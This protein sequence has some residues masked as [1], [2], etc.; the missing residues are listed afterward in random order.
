MMSALFGGMCYIIGSNTNTV[1]ALNQDETE[2]DFNC[3]DTCLD[4]LRDTSTVLLVIASILFS[5]NEIHGGKLYLLFK[6]F[7][8]TLFSDSSSSDD[9]NDWLVWV[10]TA[11]II[12]FS[13]VHV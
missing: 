1:F 11:E 3:D 5:I 2:N 8:N 6:S 10:K 12:A 13:R 7:S 9:G 4:V